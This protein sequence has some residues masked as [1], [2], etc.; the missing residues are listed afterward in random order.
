LSKDKNTFVKILNISIM[1][2]ASFIKL[3]LPK[4]KVFYNLFEEVSGTLL[5]MAKIFEKATLKAESEKADNLLK[6]LEDLEHKN[7]DTTHKIFVELG[8]NFITPFDREDIHSLATALDD[9]ADYMWAA[10]KRIV[11]YN[12]EHDDVVTTEYG[13]II[14]K[15]VKALDKAVHGLRDMKDLQS[16]TDACVVI[17][18]VENEGDELLDKAMVNMFSSSIDPKELI[19]KKDLYEVLEIVTDK[20]EDASNVIETIII[21]YS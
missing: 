20:C 2:F 1:A 14:L 10:G 12:I 13:H 18:S 11:M 7:D 17:N 5:E 9:V 16:I 4:D 3:F 6:K 19:K 8:K 15:A 21:K